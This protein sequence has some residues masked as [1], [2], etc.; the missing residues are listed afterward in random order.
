[1]SFQTLQILNK[2]NNI[3]LQQEDEETINKIYENGIEDIIN[4]ISMLS[5]PSQFNNEMPNID[6]LENILELMTNGQKQNVTFAEAEIF[7]FK[8]S[9]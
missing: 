6:E 7:L 9:N 4:Q 5:D 8:Y 1:M 3:S 2:E